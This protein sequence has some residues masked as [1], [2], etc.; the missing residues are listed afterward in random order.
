MIKNIRWD[1]LT[2][3][4]LEI[5]IPVT[6]KHTIKL[7]VKDQWV[8][9]KSGIYPPS[10]EIYCAGKMVTDCYIKRNAG[11]EISPNVINLQTALQV[12]E[13]A[14]YRMAERRQDAN[15]STSDE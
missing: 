13:E 2:A 7:H 3:E 8:D 14:E 10:L 9:Q 5:T 4:T 11:T 15:E 6:K 12:I 1:Y